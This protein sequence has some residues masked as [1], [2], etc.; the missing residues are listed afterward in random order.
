MPLKKCQEKKSSYPKELEREFSGF[1]SP[2]DKINTLGLYLFV[3]SSVVVYAS[4]T[5]NK[6]TFSCS[7][8]MQKLP[9]QRSKGGGLG[10]IQK[11]WQSIQ[12]T[13]DGHNASRVPVLIKYALAQFWSM[14]A[15]DQMTHLQ[16]CE[17]S[18]PREKKRGKIQPVSLS[19]F[20][21]ALNFCA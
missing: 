15:M 13:D 11:V 14:Q 19:L 8:K 4:A 2:S 16:N 18:A 21:K 5:K 17:P 12:Y 20:S 7:D 1:P 3:C 10:S 9:K 6:E